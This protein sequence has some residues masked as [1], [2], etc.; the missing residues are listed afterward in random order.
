MARSRSSAAQA[1]ARGAGLRYVTDDSVGIVRRRRGR[2]FTYTS[3]DGSQVRDEPTLERIRALAIPPAWTQVWI[4]PAENAHIQAVGRDARGRKQYRYHALW[5]AARDEQKY[6]HMLAFARALP[7]LRHRVRCDLRRLPM[8]RDHVLAT[9]VSLLER[10]FIRIGNDEYARANRSYGLTTL[11]HGHV[12]VKGK[13]VQFCFRAKSGVTQ[14]LTVRDEALARFVRQC[15]VL[16]GDHLFQCLRE[17]GQRTPIDSNDVNAYLR[18]ATGLQCS[19]KD[20]R[21]WA[22]TVLAAIHL[23]AEQDVTTVTA[24]RKAIVRAVDRVA[25]RLGNTRAVC[26]SSYIHPGVIEAYLDGETIKPGATVKHEGAACCRLPEAAETAVL[27]LL[28]RRRQAG[29]RRAA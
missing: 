14:E 7:A 12:S 5:R 16:P 15:K 22:G 11:H 28:R 29:V 8:S 20:F 6:D 17:D 9:L 1:F 10:T 2:R 3:A 25:E 26:R 21:T 19:A 13:D 27:S 23:S 18:D 24:K 4:A